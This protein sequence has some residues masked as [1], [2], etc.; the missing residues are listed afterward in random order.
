[1]NCRAFIDIAEAVAIGCVVFGHVLEAGVL[2]DA[3]GGASGAAYFGLYLFHM[4][5]LP[6]FLVP[7]P[8]VARNL[9]V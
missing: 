7:R 9:A 6:L 5:F 2:R 3:G 8:P 1:M 4:P